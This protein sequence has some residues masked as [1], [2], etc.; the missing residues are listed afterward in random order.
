MIVWKSK[1]LEKI[2]LF[3]WLVEKQKKRPSSQRTT[4]LGE[5]GREIPGVT[6][7]GNLSVVII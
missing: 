1:L 5:D 6:Y 7:V 3:M 2:K 4:C